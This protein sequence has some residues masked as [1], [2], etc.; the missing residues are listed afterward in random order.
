MSESL[1]ERGGLNIA[2][3]GPLLTR[4]IAGCAGVATYIAGLEEYYRDL[5]VYQVLG[6]LAALS[7]PV[8]RSTGLEDPEAPAAGSFFQG[9]LLG[10]RAVEITQDDGF[11]SSLTEQSMSVTVPATDAEDRLHALHQLASAVQAM[12]DEGYN[13]CESLHPLLDEWDVLAT[14][15][16]RTAAYFKRG[17]GLS[18]W[19]ARQ[20]A[21]KKER[22][23]FAA[24]CEDAGLDL[25]EWSALEAEFEA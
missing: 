25:D 22:A 3:A 20:Q 9:T 1:G 15:D 7:E 16:A 17:F 12:A 19:F 8:D 4:E 23:E 2:A 6:S 24:F 18:I 5:P 11:L 10:L 14:G 21:T 13:M